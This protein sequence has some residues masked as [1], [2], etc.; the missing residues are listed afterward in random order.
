MVY[1]LDSEVTRIADEYFSLLARAFPVMC[2]SDE[3]HFL[4]R[5]QKAGE[6]LERLDD[7]SQEAIANVVEKVHDL[8]TRLNQLPKV[9]N[10]EEE[11]DRQLLLHNMA[12]L[13]IELEE[14]NSWR[15]NPLLYLKVGC[16]GVD[17]A[18][19][20]PCTAESECLRRAAERIAALK[21]LLKEAAENLDTIPG[22]YY[23]TAL[24]MTGDAQRYFEEILRKLALKGNEAEL[25][26]PCQEAQEALSAF[27]SEL[28][29]VGP[30]P[31]EAVRPVS[32]EE[33]V[34]RHFGCTRTLE[35]IYA[36][37]E[38][39]WQDNLEEMD[40]LRHR[41]DASRDWLQLYESY[42]P[43]SGEEL[44]LFRHYGDEI[45]GLRE[46]CSGL[47]L[48]GGVSDQ[49]VVLAETPTY[50][51]SVRSGASYSSPLS[52]NPLE[53]AIFYIT[54]RSSN[55][56]SHMDK[57]RRQRLHREYRFLT[58]H[59]T[60]PGHHL[61]D[62]VRRSLDNPIRRQVESPLFYEGWAYYAESILAERGWV[63]EPLELLVDCKR[64][65]WRAARCLID[66]GLT[67]HKLTREKAAD[68]LVSVGFAADEAMGQVERFR[69][70]PGY[71]LCYSLGKYEILE[72][73][74]R[75]Q[76]RLGWVSFHRLLLDGGELPFN[77]ASWRLEELTKDRRIGGPAEPATTSSP[78]RM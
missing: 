34:Q 39:E 38:E 32:V 68:L 5:V 36:I 40:K 11:I 71:Q 6:Y 26:G 10:F 70:N 20:K 62:S 14:A 53:Q 74:R 47:D 72:L 44:D 35:E 7:L 76:P 31:A 33:L 21:R 24:A 65:L 59:E 30:A 73:R 52:L 54:N 43:T 55:G 48:L 45:V 13:L 57:L 63:R 51:L 15:H 8:D 78:G 50:L 67:L 61:L 58:A 19:N 60:Y 28:R 17:H 2:A 23:R 22:P 49:Q 75:F 46:F 56:N 64:R 66:V 69:L 4:P 77:L 37:A 1:N 9:T 25:E 16:I 41:I 3:F 12:G 42:R 29:A 18:L 27:A